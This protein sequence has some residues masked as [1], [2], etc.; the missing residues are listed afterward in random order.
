[1]I[2]WNKNIRPCAHLGAAPCSNI[3]INSI[4]EYLLN[5]HFQYYFVICSDNFSLLNL[6]RK[7]T[8][9]LNSKQEGKKTIYCLTRWGKMIFKG[10]SLTS[11]S[12]ET[13][14]T[15]FSMCT[16][17]SPW[18]HGRK[19]CTV[20][21]LEKREWNLSSLVRNDLNMNC[22]PYRGKE[23]CRLHTSWWSTVPY[24]NALEWRTPNMNM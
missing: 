14:A 13:R 9:F 11:S 1:M 19:G 5:S 23:W 16:C 22:L 2:V 7:W 12:F 10:T 4:N 8:L 17:Q 20:Q 21:Y 15:I 18:I 24:H 6:T 3:K